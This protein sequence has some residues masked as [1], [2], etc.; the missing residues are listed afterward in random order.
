MI[1]V[2]FIQ[3]KAE[4][5]GLSIAAL[6]RKADLYNGAINNMRESNPTIESLKK[7]ADVLGCTLDDLLKKEAC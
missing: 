4:E 2:S 7:V 3:K 5:M 1:D 6:E